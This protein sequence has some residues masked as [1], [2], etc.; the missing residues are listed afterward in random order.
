[1]KFTI[2]ADIEFMLEKDNALVSAIPVLGHEGKELPHGRIFFDN[3]LAEFTVDPASDKDAFV[4]N[5]W[6]NFI[7]AKELF[8]NDGI[9]VKIC[10]SAHYPKK[11]L[12]TDEA[13]LFGC[14]PDFCAYDVA[15]NEVS[16]NA[17]ETTL[18]TA[19]AHIHFCHEIFQDPYKI[20]DMI[21]LMDLRLGVLS[22]IKDNT[23]EAIERRSLYGAAGAHR[24]KEYPGGEYRPLSNWWIK[25]RESIGLIYDKTEQC[26]IDIVDGKTVASLGF[27]DEDIRNIINTGNVDSAHNVLIALENIK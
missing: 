10:S 19:G 2:G 8:K 11:E 17:D 13:K 9:D 25:D 4:N 15:I 23:P 6:N 22:V 14:S 21:K 26:L 20:L 24:P 16:C 1:M 5:V 3:V 12:N 7:H 27:N 18:R